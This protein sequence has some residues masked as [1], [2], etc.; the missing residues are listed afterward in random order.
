MEVQDANQ[1]DAQ[2]RQVTSDQITTHLHV[3]VAAGA[4]SL[5]V[6]RGVSEIGS[7]PEPC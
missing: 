4:L 2:A 7:M 3:R 5:V 6:L 1:A